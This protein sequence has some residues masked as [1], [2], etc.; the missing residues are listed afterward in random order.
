M[1]ATQGRYSDWIMSTIANS[2]RSWW[3][4]RRAR[5][6]TTVLSDSTLFSDAT[7]CCK[8]GKLAES[9]GTRFVALQRAAAP[10]DARSRIQ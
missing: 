9:G 4:H 1:D 10:I 3:Y 2:S 7:D 6:A 5:R 8:L